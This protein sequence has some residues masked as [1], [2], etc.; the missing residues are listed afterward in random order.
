MTSRPFAL[1]SCSGDYFLN[2]IPLSSI[3][4][5]KQKTTQQQAETILDTTLLKRPMK[6]KIIAAYL[7]VF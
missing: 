3:S 5:N 2:C 7:K 4:I 1:P 6:W